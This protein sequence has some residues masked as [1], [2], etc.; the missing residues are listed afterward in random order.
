M[1][2]RL[3]S[4]GHYLPVR[5]VKNDDLP[6]S[7]KT[8][9]KW[10][11]ERT[12]I[13]ER[14]ISSAKETPS[15]MAVEA[16]KKA[17][18]MATAADPQF[19]PDSIDFILCATTLPDFLCPNTATVIQKGLG[20]SQ[21]CPCLDITSACSGFLYGLV[22][23]D[24]LL[25]SGRYKKILLLGAEQC[26]GFANWSDRTSCILFGDGAGALILQNQQPGSE[27]KVGL[28]HSVL[29]AD[30]S[31]N[32]YLKIPA[33]GA[34]RPLT[35][36]GLETNQNKLSMSGREVFKDAVTQMS[37]LS[38]RCLKEA[39]M[40]CDEIDWFVPHQANVRIIDA[41]AEKLGVPQEKIIVNIQQTAN[42]S[43]ASIPIA[44]DQ[45]IRDEKIK[46][47]DRILFAAYG[48]GATSGVAIFDY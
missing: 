17:F 6:A 28:R 41:V 38:L 30:G 32:D 11:R 47:G 25:A 14:R 15:F 20:L 4:T 40:G 44:L 21:N 16:T 33:G 22:V 29:A 12:G 23:A 19:S 26:S 35:P 34:A 36:E 5:I 27:P 10:I 7:L 46:R 48:G 2:S 8:N 37:S 24:S 18:E 13:L 39:G 1:T 45:A 9:D 43:A 31:K 3:L 42:T